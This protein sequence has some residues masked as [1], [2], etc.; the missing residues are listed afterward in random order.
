M[1]LDPP[2]LAPGASCA[3]LG[4]ALP[5]HCRTAAFWL[6]ASEDGKW[7][8]YL[9][10]PVVDAAGLAKAYRLL[11]PLVRARPRPF[12]IDPLEIK[13]TGPSNPI[14]RDVLGIHGRVRGPHGSPLPWGGTKLG[15]RSI[16]GAYLYPLPAATPSP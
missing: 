16:E 4:E 3:A 1:S 5:T 14:A 10:S 11:H 12:W 9:V 15:N 8:F 13:L 2:A 6:K 7:S